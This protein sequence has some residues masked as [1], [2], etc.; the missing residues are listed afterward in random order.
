MSFKTITWWTLDLVYNNESKMSI[1]ANLSDS[2]LE[3]SS[4]CFWWRTLVRPLRRI[5]RQLPSLSLSWPNC[6]HKTCVTAC[7]K[8]FFWIYDH[9]E[10]EYRT[11]TLVKHTE[12]R[13]QRPIGPL[14]L[15]LWS[16]IIPSHRWKDSGLPTAREASLLLGLLALSV[17][18]SPLK[19]YLS[20]LG[21]LSACKD[22]RSTGSLCL[23]FHL[24]VDNT[25]FYFHFGVFA[26]GDGCQL[27]SVKKRSSLKEI[28]HVRWC[29]TSWGIWCI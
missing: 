25:V 18:S 11:N 22:L 13:V 19:R 26:L 1:E 3:H 16:L 9:Q 10:Q 23:H 24:T 14:S 17:T 4:S 29:Y 27:S 15:P 21:L 6:A 28:C 7:P 20:F 5:D 2:V 8:V 12:I